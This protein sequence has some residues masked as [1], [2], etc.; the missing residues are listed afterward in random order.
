LND[1]KGNSNDNQSEDGA[2]N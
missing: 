2:S 1:I